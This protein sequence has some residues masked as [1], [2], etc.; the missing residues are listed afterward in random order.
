MKLRFSPTSPYVRKVAITLVE[1]GLNDRVEKIP[2]LP[3][4]A[5]TDLGNDNPLGKVPALVLD[6][7][8]VMYDSPVICEYLDSLH[9]GDK[10]F[11]A[12][13][14]ARW[15]ALNMQALGDGMSDAG[16][17]WLIETRR[18]ED[19]QYDKWIKRQT[20]TI[21]RAMDA[22]EAVT[23]ELE[24][25]FGIGQISVASSLG[26]LDFRFSDLDWRNQRSGLADW[27]EEISDR[28]S[29]TQTVP[30]EG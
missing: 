2:T 24:A 8:N 27:F 11:P 4:D 30:K 15:R 21:F 28:P 29:M 18:P 5:K 17:Y 13:G 16:V 6:D 1:T 9:D 14:N 12:S 23:D 10:L 26:W 20:A 3:W 25:G 7:G 22:L 19:L